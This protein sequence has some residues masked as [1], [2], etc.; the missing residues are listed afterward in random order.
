MKKEKNKTIFGSQ[1]AKERE[2]VRQL[3]QGG[4]HFAIT[5]VIIIAIILY[6]IL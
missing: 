2:V 4:F 1:A 3:F 6:F 5:L